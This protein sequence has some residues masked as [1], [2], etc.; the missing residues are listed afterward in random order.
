MTA[1]NKQK[2]RRVAAEKAA[3]QFLRS[4][5]RARTRGPDFDHP[6]NQSD[7]VLQPVGER[8][9]GDLDELMRQ[10][11]VEARSLAWAGATIP[12]IAAYFGVSIPTIYAWGAKHPE[13]LDA[14]KVG[15]Q[16]A[17]DRI[18]GSLYH[19][20]TEGD[21]TA[22]IFWLK[23]RRP[24]DWR[25]RREIELGGELTMNDNLGTRELALATLQMLREAMQEPVPDM[26][27]IDESPPSPP[28]DLDVYTPASDR[29]RRRFE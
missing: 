20:A 2:R 7:L 3:R 25:D 29:P 11:C 13:L 15:R 24:K 21:N 8:R 19:R 22:A 23:N 14:I 16:Y 18:E 17:D 9:L 26:L 4:S 1:P 5:K 28:Q 27:V 10:R 12:E 6:I